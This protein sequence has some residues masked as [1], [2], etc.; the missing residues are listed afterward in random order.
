[1][2]FREKTGHFTSDFQTGGFT[3]FSHRRAQ[4]FAT[5]GVLDQFF[6]VDDPGSGLNTGTSR[7]NAR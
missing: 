1:M 2:R 3:G 6:S 5:G 7:Q 4:S